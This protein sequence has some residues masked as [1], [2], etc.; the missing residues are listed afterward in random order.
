MSCSILAMPFREE[1]FPMEVN[2]LEGARFTSVDLLIFY[3]GLL[4][5]KD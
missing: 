1:T 4:L 3:G 5:A 2:F